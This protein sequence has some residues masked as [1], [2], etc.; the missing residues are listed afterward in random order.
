MP[1]QHLRKIIKDHGDMSA[2]KFRHDKR[3][4]LGALKYVP[5]AIF[6]L[7][8]NMPMPWEEVR[9]V[10][11]LYHMTGAITFVN[12]IPWVVEPIYIA[13][14]GTM[15]MMMRKEK[16]DRRHFKRMRFPPFD[17]EEPPLDY[18]ENILD[19]EPVEGIQMELDP[20]ED[21]PV[22]EWFYD[23]QPLKRSKLVNGPSYKRWKLT[24]PIMSTLY[25]LAGQLLS[26]LT[27]PNYF[28][29][30][31][32][33]S[34]FTAKALNMAIPG[35]PKFEP[36]FR[37]IEAQDEDWNEFN[38]IHK[39]I[40]RHPIRTESRIAF[41]FLYNDRP[42]KVFVT[43]YHHPLVCYMKTE[44]PNLPAFFWDPLINPI[45]GMKS[46]RALTEFEEELLEGEEDDFSLPEDVEPFLIDTPLFSG[47]TAAGIALY[48][49]PHPFNERTG[50]MRRALDIPLVKPW[51]LERCPPNQPVKVR[52]SYQKLL[53]CYVHNC[54]KKRP[55]KSLKRRALFKS[56]KVTKFFQ[57][58]EI[59]WVEAGLQV[60]RQGYNMLN[61]L[62]H[63][64]NLNY[65]H[66]DYNFMLK[67]IKTLTTKERK[68]SR[69]GNAFHLCRE[70]LRLTK[71]VVDS[72]V[73]YR[74]GN[75]DAYQLADGLQ[76]IFAHVGH[77][78]GMYRYKYRLMRQI[79]M[80]F[81]PETPVMMA[82]GTTKAIKDVEVG[83]EVMGDT[84]TSRKVV[85]KADG[86]AQMYRVTYD[87]KGDKS[88]W[89]DEGSSSSFVCNG[90]HQLVV[91]VKSDLHIDTT[92]D[93]LRVTYCKMVQDDNLGFEV[94]LLT[95]LQFAVNPHAYDME[96]NAKAKAKVAAETKAHELQVL[97]YKTALTHLAKQ[98]QFRVLV[99]KANRP[100]GADAKDFAFTYSY[101]RTGGQY[102]LTREKAVA[103]SEKFFASCKAELVWEPTVE[104]WLR[105]EEQYPR[106][107][108]KCKMVRVGRPSAITNPPVKLLSDLVRESIKQVADNH[109]PQPKVSLENA[110]P[111]LAFLVGVWLGAGHNKSPSIYMVLNEETRS[112]YNGL[113]QIT[114]DLGLTIGKRTMSNDPKHAHLCH[115]WYVTFSS[116]S[117]SRK[118]KGMSEN[119]LGNCTQQNVLCVLLKRLGF[120][121]VS[122]KHLSEEVILSVVCDSQEVRGALLAGLIDT[123]GHL[124]MNRMWRITQK[125]HDANGM[126]HKSILDLAHRTALSLG[127]HS[128]R[129][130]AKKV[131]KST[132][133]GKPLASGI[134]GG[135]CITTPPVNDPISKF[136][137]TDYKRITESS[138][139]MLRSDR[140]RQLYRFKVSKMDTPEGPYVGI[141]VEGENERFLLGDHVSVHNC[142]DLKHLIY[143]RFNTGPVGKGP[144]CGFWAPGWRVWLFFLR[145][146]VPLLE[147]WLGNLLARQFEG[148]HSKG[149]A[150]TVTKQRVE[151]HFDLELRAAVMH[152]I[153][154][155]MPEGLKQNKSRTILQHLSEAWRCFSPS[156]P[157]RMADGMTKKAGDIV[158]GDLVLGSKGQGLPVLHTMNGR[159]RMYRV[160]LLPDGVNE[161]NDPNWNF[162]E[163]GFVCN[164]RHELV[165]VN[166]QLGG[167]SINHNATRRV[168]EVH[169]AG[170][171]P[172][173]GPVPIEKHLGHICRTFS[174]SENMYRSL[175]ASKDA[176]EAEAKYLK[177]SGA[178]NVRVQVNYKRGCVSVSVASLNGAVR[179]HSGTFRFGVSKLNGTTDTDRI[180]AGEAA[181]KAAA[182]SYVVD[183]AKIP[184]MWSVSV[185]DYLAYCKAHPQHA[186]RLRMVFC[187]QIEFPRVIHL[188]K[189]F[190]N[191]DDLLN[192]MYASNL[193]PHATAADVAYLLGLHLADGKKGHAKFFLGLHEK[194]IID[195]LVAIAPT[196]G[197]VATL[198]KP[199]TNCQPVYLSGCDFRV[200]NSRKRNTLLSLFCHLG[201][202]ID[203]TKKVSG[204]LWKNIVLQDSTFR[205][206]VLAGLIDG[207]GT[208]QIAHRNCD[209]PHGY[210][211]VQGV[212]SEYSKHHEDIMFLVRDISRS[213]GLNCFIFRRSNGYPADRVRLTC[214][215]TGDGVHLIP[216][217]EKPLMKHE[218]S[219]N[220]SRFRGYVQF[221]V[222]KASENGP[223]CGF[224][225]EGSPLFLLK[226]WLIAHNC[227]K[228][229][230]PWK[231]PGLPIAIENMILRYVKSKADWWTNVAHYNR[232]RIRRGATV[233]KTVCLSPDTEVRMWDGSVRTMTE[234][235]VGDLLVGDDSTPR[236]VI[237][238]WTGM[239]DVMYEINQHNGMTY[240]CTGK[241]Q[242]VARLSGCKQQC[243]VDKRSGKWCVEW[244][245]VENKCLMRNYG[246][247]AFN[248]EEEARNFLVTKPTITT[249]ELAELC[250]ED[251]HNQFKSIR[252]HVFGVRVGVHT[253][254][255]SHNHPLLLE[256]Y[257]LGLW[258]GDGTTSGRPMVTTNDE[259]IVMYLKG[260]AK[261]LNLSVKAQESGRI[262]ETDNK[263]FSYYLASPHGQ[264]NQ[265][266]EALRHY[267]VL[268]SKCIPNDYMGAS[269]A[270]RLSLLAG[271]LDSNG[272]V[273]KDKF[274]REEY[275]TYGLSFSQG[276]N[277][278]DLLY[279]F[280]DLCRSLGFAG[281]EVRQYTA[282]VRKLRKRKKDNVEMMR[283]QFVASGPTCH[284]VPTLLERKR[285]PTDAC[286]RDTTSGIPSKLELSKI[287]AL[288]QPY[289]GVTVS[290]ANH[291]FLLRDYTVTHN[292]KKN[293][294]RLT[295]LWLKAEQER[296]HNYLKDGPYISAE[297]AVAIYTTTVHWLESRKFSPIPFPPLNYKH[298]TK[299]LILA[300]ERLKEAYSVM[301]RLN[302]SQREELGLIEQAY[303]NPH[304]ALS[305]IKRHLLTQ[306]AFKEVGIEFMDLYSHLVPVYDVEPLEK[307][308]DAYLDQYLWYE[309]DKRHLFPGWI[310]PGDS[311]PP[312]LLVY[313]WCQGINNLHNVWDTS[314]GECVVMLETKLEKIYE[315]VDLTLLNRLLRL[316]LDHN[317]ADYITAKNN[318]V[319][320]YKDMNHTN[321]YGL[322]RGLQFAS[323]IVQFY[324]LV[325]DL[326]LLGLTRASE[327][328]GPPEM[329]NDF[330][331]FHSL[332]M[333]TKHPIRLYSRYIDR[334]HICYRVT[335]D[336]AK[337]LIQR[338]LTEH[339]DPNN[340]NIVGYPNR[341]CWPR[342]CRM[343]LMKHDVNLGRALFW[344]LKNRLPRSVS[345]IEWENS[346]VSV[347]SKDNP[348][349]LFNMCGFEVRVL[350]K[351]RAINE[352]FTNKD[353]VWNLQNEST[354]ERTAQAF[355]RVDEESLKRYENR[356]RMILM[357]SGSTTFTKIVNKWN[358]SLIGLMT[359]FREAVVHTQEL[360]D[361]LVKCENKIQ[362]R[363]K[364]G[365]NSKMPSRFPPVV[366][367]CV[368]PN[369]PVRMAD[370]SEKAMGN[371][372][373]GELVLG[374]DGGIRT[375]AHIHS[376][377]APLYRVALAHN[378]MDNFLFNDSAFVCN[379]NHKLVISLIKDEASNGLRIDTTGDM[380]SV[381]GSIGCR[382]LTL[383]FDPHLG[384]ERP[385]E[386]ECCIK[387]NVNN[388]ARLIK[389][390]GYDV[391][392]TRAEAIAAA[393]EMQK[394]MSVTEWHVSTSVYLEYERGVREGRGLHIPLKMRYGASI[395]EWPV[396][397]LWRPSLTD[398]I[399]EGIAIVGLVGV[400][401]TAEQ[402]AWMIGLWL[403][404]G[405]AKE[406]RI[407]VGDDDWPEL[408]PKFEEFGAAC[409]L[410]INHTS[411][412]QERCGRVTLE[413]IEKR[414]NYKLNLLNIVLSNLGLLEEKQVSTRTEEILITES[415]N[416]RRSLIA[417]LIDS[418]GFVRHDV[419]TDRPKGYTFT[420]SIRANHESI[421]HLFYIISRSLGL[422]TFT[423]K[424]V[425]KDTTQ[426]LNGRAETGAKC[427][428]RG[429]IHIAGDVHMLP[430][431]LSKKKID[432]PT[433]QHN[434][435]V[436]TFEITK[437]T[438]DGDYVGFAVGEGE[439]PLFCLGDFLV[440]HNTPK[441]LGGLGMLSMG[442]VLIPQSD[443]RY[444]K[445]TD[446]GITHF[447]SG[448]SHEEGQLIPNLYRYIQP[449][450]MEFIDSQRVWAEYA[451]KRQEANAQNRR[452]T[453]EDLEDSWDKG[454]PRINTLFQKDRHTLAYDKGW[455]VRT[456]FKQYQLLKNN[457][458]WWTH[459][460]HDGKLWNL[461]NYRTDM[462]QAL[463]GVEGILEHTLFKGT[464]FPTWEGLFWEK[465]CFRIDTELMLATG[466]L[467]WQK[468]SK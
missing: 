58:T 282:G 181:A 452:L 427:W 468:M 262:G 67:P 89:D 42:R 308:T 323:F 151:S 306:R 24:V 179:K 432:Q 125:D 461:N 65:L 102:Y 266:L 202:G 457:P 28:Y 9:D 3:V 241:H 144:G 284:D 462:I 411:D 130:R 434:R 88:A 333:E 409:G 237:E 96:P 301:A 109:G 290:G 297:E 437:E 175:K 94:P 111:K 141:Q 153:L 390:K 388:F 118:R 359:Y 171:V 467:F 402:M 272:W 428:M 318:I 25:R 124:E 157:V 336:E 410:K 138:H 149:I 1:P 269:R 393:E 73:Q 465:A 150:K 460:R 200:P 76:Y 464:Y 187:D 370:G 194:K 55:P 332:V 29:L 178:S 353:G 37:D 310:K 40:I 384:A 433:F 386:V 110:I 258:L 329:P 354:K 242:L 304:E 261:R 321:S 44:D 337:E 415:G 199:V 91:I 298:D 371:I 305:R 270:D 176:A 155:M 192:D 292:C 223:Y 69:F 34:F 140:N 97:G 80:C 378:K 77:L 444:A 32:L 289:V 195:Y 63:R 101:N 164:S 364:I 247:K 185:E 103:A 214:N 281:C 404:G 134:M 117:K 10:N 288:E 45:P 5:H 79:R 382:F 286:W 256:P 423:R 39:I 114:D 50:H 216:C 166:P 159:D 128:S 394:T 376:G 363:I 137:L 129:C 74:L 173:K 2:K 108:K 299:L 407:S 84:L 222:T 132:L 20:D 450:E 328:A 203:D 158:K 283:W 240:R 35:G 267:G 167:V 257:M 165:L 121:E 430:V 248:T 302:Q 160:D 369:T 368:A 70:I 287:E 218:C 341:K 379:G 280:S 7:L 396:R 454:I 201:Y 251:V 380:N 320:N 23:H 205:R 99:P 51:F 131:Y 123:D 142:K 245:T 156:T 375:V 268:H 52:V 172:Y 271:F 366:F 350:P 75:L 387:W 236:T 466:R 127:L 72:Y 16:R 440:T 219:E 98:G 339:P 314:N 122:N 420:Q 458:F 190:Y 212:D 90:P 352:S 66:L 169:S 389:E 177:E 120:Y 431:A 334:I 191:V 170:L 347:Y 391:Y 126:H 459:Q 209:K 418:D 263:F 374:D 226:N 296:Q 188:Q 246:P 406:T 49:A 148:R 326:L 330:L 439:S 56:L 234:V 312:P 344:D 343:R 416:V 274:P 295:R 230:I 54:L 316:I 453:L 319:M 61:L 426:E 373:L 64:K 43:P 213:L 59:D 210:G 340:E 92:T 345:T 221:K 335:H 293:L 19:I 441:E 68:K 456:D 198:E 116:A 424:Y 224:Q 22:Y 348:N 357:A 408:K 455:R 47:N 421:L 161:G 154:D 26:D 184:A 136:I 238:R 338:Y 17:D 162:E 147:R 395:E 4:Y 403:G 254:R 331:T 260:F 398:I 86:L 87:N 309:A 253:D 208:Y 311:E 327:I 220:P 239:T 349:L 105:F 277:H 360:L 146:I 325:L 41:P 228:A 215:I 71:F 225:L 358:T 303:D 259:E 449:W 397:S 436:R 206:A 38:D 365:L 278:K 197:M 422:M 243:Y 445:Q 399:N 231:V 85:A 300:L 351:M 113:Q 139:N 285:V 15:W 211:F 355:L 207:D 233:D 356:V 232:E 324:G 104:Q 342:D 442:H 12:E 401:V 193:L 135:T 217:K 174:Y 443:L 361:L 417:G 273:H 13:Q 11:V 425:V 252:S 362:T 81:D 189:Q 36:L 143:Y 367:Y 163:D 435:Q 346:F 78:T 107:A 412:P 291:R 255:A 100:E 14:W 93:I 317:I 405:T 448:L 62:I 413:P 95:A 46:S 385:Y 57:T 115:E 294:G 438:E 414:T 275:I 182:E 152:D 83:E 250:V 447:R 145:G 8:E 48:W 377:K 392:N 451:L 322:I 133:R 372:E 244:W 315:K 82:N 30:F 279:D 400:T 53:K 186:D 429:D 119:N 196:F 6:K 419:N 313:K 264:P 106:R 180:F 168:F 446:I 33:K 112:F 235:N 18:G 27:D 383:K 229:N 60:C 21:E 183:C 463:G 307:I 31:D 249:G 381:R 276:T 265:F 204:K 227:F